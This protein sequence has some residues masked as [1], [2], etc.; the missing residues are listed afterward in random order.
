MNPKEIKGRYSVEDFITVS[1]KSAFDNL[2]DA[3]QF[4]KLQ[5]KFHEKPI[6]I[7]EGHDIWYVCYNGEVFAWNEELTKYKNK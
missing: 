6:G 2:A 5:S 4:G 3:I 1:E 7:W